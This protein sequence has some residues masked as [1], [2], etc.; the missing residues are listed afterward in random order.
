VHG[1]GE[2]LV[3]GQHQIRQ[4]FHRVRLRGPDEHRALPVVLPH[5]GERLGEQRVPPRRGH[6]WPRLVEQLQH[7]LGRAVGEERGELVPDGQEPLGLPRRV[8][9]QLVEVVDVQH[10]VHAAGQQA[11]DN[12]RDEVEERRFDRVRRVRGGVVGPAH[13]QAHGGEPGGDRRVQLL[14]RGEPV[15]PGVQPAAERHPRRGRDLQVAHPGDAS[16]PGGA[17]PVA[18]GA[19]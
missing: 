8:V 18:G 16:A 11:V 14:P 12:G 3:V 9:V 19:R 10:D 2:A 7:Q 13:R 17:T 6:R 15:R 5:H 1:D 4:P